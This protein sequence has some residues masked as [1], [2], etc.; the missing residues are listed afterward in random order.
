MSDSTMPILLAVGGV[1][2]FHTA[3][4]LEGRALA[5]QI[6]TTGAFLWPP[7]LL[8]LVHV[9]D[10]KCPYLLLPMLWPLAVWAVDQHL[11]YHA[12]TPDVEASLRFEP[13]SVTAMVFGL[14]GLLG[15]R[16]DAEYAHLF[17]MAV[18]ACVLVV[19]PSHT[20]VDPKLPEVIVITNVQR[21][22]LVWS[23]ALMAAGVVLTRKVCREA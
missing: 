11:L 10:R 22:V 23:I 7:L 2:L 12:S 17:L 16:G 15:A 1:V 9:K 18:L 14:C 6:R 13:T 19:L 8:S 3:R 21:T 4:K 20:M 5:S